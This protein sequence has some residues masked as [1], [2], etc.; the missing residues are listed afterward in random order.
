MM[1][2]HMNHV[3]HVVSSS[4][5]AAVTGGIGISDSA[6]SVFDF[7]CCMMISRLV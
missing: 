6:L 4:L 1:L 7:S 5:D 3:N 2:Y